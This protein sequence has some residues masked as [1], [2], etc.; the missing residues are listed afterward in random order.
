MTVLRLFGLPF[1]H[2]IQALFLI[3]AVFAFDLCRKLKTYDEG[4]NKPS[5]CTYKAECDDSPPIAASY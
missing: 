5:E 2:D 1:H 3:R 4:I